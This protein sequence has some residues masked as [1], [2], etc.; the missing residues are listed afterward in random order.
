[1]KNAV[2]HHDPWLPNIWTAN[3]VILRLVENNGLPIEHDID[4]GLSPLGEIQR[5]SK[6]QPR[7]GIMF[8]GSGGNPSIKGVALPNPNSKAAT[9]GA[10]FESVQTVSNKLNMTMEQICERGSPIA[11][12]LAG[13]VLP[14]N[15][16]TPISNRRRVAPCLR[17]CTWECTAPNGVSKKSLLKLTTSLP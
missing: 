2:D 17:R 11:V 6:N 13:D 8:Y 12:I 14:L 9:A 1:M 5:V 15:S 7:K 16:K 10:T 4:K 3:A